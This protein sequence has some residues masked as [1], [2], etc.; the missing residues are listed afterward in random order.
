M[1]SASSDQMPPPSMLRGTARVVSATR[2]GNRGARYAPCTMQLVVELPGVTPYAWSHREMAVRLRSWPQP[3]MALPVLVDVANDHRLTVLWKDVPDHEEVGRAQAEQLAA[4]M[5][6]AGPS[7]ATTTPSGTPPLPPHPSP[8]SS[9]LP[10]PPPSAVPSAGGTGGGTGGM[11]VVAGNV[12]GD[13]VMR[14][15]K[16]AQLR[17]AGIVDETQFTQLRAQILEQAG[18]G[19]NDSRS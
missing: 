18:L 10:P 13:P 8:T 16:L 3:G 15:E 7:A 9:S 11:P 1:S 4:M 14:L 12:A 6:A 17:A 5:R 2:P 19:E